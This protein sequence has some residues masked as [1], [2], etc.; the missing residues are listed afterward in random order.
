M[1]EIAKYFM[2][3]AI[4]Q[5]LIKHIQDTIMPRQDQIQ[6]PQ[7]IDCQVFSSYPV[8]QVS[9]GFHIID[10]ELT[11]AAKR[12][13]F[14]SGNLMGVND[15][16]GMVV[17][18]PKFC[19]I[20]KERLG[21]ILQIQEI[22]IMKMDRLNI[23]GTPQ[24]YYE[25]KSIFDTIYM[26]VQSMQQKALANYIDNI[27]SIESL[28]EGANSRIPLAINLDEIIT[29]QK[30]PPQ[31]FLDL[32]EDDLT[33]L[34]NTTEK[35][36]TI[37]P[38]QQNK[39]TEKDLIG[40]FINL[41]DP[42]KRVLQEQIVKK[43]TDNSNKTNTNLASPKVQKETYVETQV[44]STPKKTEESP[45]EEWKL[46]DLKKFSKWRVQENQM[47]S[48]G[49]VQELIQSQIQQD[50]SID[51]VIVK[52]DQENKTN[53]LEPPYKKKCKAKKNEN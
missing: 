47:K 51:F 14:N 35:E 46:S 16:R 18:I 1:N 15:F 28:I 30:T 27:P 7:I 3:P 10:C 26:K 32:T 6:V 5:A 22:S 19:F 39:N 44:S 24:F 17:S 36:R 13:L 48:S 9:D 29:N 31:K 50:S 34:L 52:R 11:E 33:N 37:P 49:R 25:D 21:F 45:S 53:E 23:I 41:P 8:F 40:N 2:V 20:Q 43:I 12:Y 42:L 4:K 38:I